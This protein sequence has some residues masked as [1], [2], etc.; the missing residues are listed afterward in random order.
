M[1][2]RDDKYVVFK[3]EDYQEWLSNAGATL[4]PLEDAVVIRTQDIFAAPALYAY[5]NCISTC[6]EILER[7][8]QVDGNRASFH[9]AY[10]E[11]LRT[12]EEYFMD[13]GDEADNH[14]SKK[15]PD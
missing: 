13:R 3:L 15:V 7:V 8:Q 4:S 10:L 1:G 2:M 5:A 9:P 11:R 6:R 14:A 12:I